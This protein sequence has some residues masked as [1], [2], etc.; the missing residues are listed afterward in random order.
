MKVW[1]WV[2]MAATALAVLS[3]RAAWAGAAMTYDGANRL[4]KTV[5]T[6]SVTTYGYDG[7]G[8]LVRECTGPDQ[9][10]LVCSDLI[11]DGAALPHVVGKVT[12]ANQVLHAYGPSGFAAQQAVVAGTAQGVE[13]ALTD[14][15][16]SVRG[17]VSSAGVVSARTS[18]DAYG[19]VRAQAGTSASSLGYTGE[20]T[21]ADGVVNL[22]ARSYLPEIG[23]FVQRDSLAFG[24]DTPQGLNRYA[25]VG[26]NAV[27]LADPTGHIPPHRSRNLF[28][29]VNFQR[30]QE[31][32][33]RFWDNLDV[34][35]ALR[36]VVPR[37]SNLPLSI[38]FGP[39]AMGDLLRG[40]GTDAAWANLEIWKQITG[41][42]LRRMLQAPGETTLSREPDSGRIPAVA[43]R[44]RSPR[45]T[46]PGSQVA[47][48]HRNFTR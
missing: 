44:A 8:N 30:A 34:Q 1:T 45:S 38:L 5:K 40:G 14:Q 13:Y 11:V 27:N 6:G 22:R 48:I 43:W 17:L 21:G 10:S 33:S 25:Y 47:T 23:R 19:A 35:S 12:G 20:Y 28:S 39:N 36:G 3:P 15:Q 26:N 46:R 41:D 29:E 4:V 32:Q 9:A 16:G 18:Y 37:G 2:L 31:L 42:S 24:G 7:E